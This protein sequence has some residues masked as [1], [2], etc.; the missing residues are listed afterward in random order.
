MQN[1]IAKLNVDLAAK[2]EKEKTLEEHIRHHEEQMQY[3]PRHLQN[4]PLRPTSPPP[5]TI[6]ND[7]RQGVNDAFEDVSGNG[8]APPRRCHEALRVSADLHRG[9]PVPLPLCR[10]G[11][12]LLQVEEIPFVE[13]Q[14]PL[15]AHGP[16]FPP[17]PRRTRQ[18]IPS[19]SLRLFREEM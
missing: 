11:E 16:F 17:P 18:K 3:I 19:A 14:I 9:V 8:G 5:N 2:E 4:E 13:D 1:R 6:A 15:Q 7:S 12:E 10:L